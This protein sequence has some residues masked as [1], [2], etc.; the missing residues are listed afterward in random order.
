M[1]KSISEISNIH[2][3]EI[4]F[5][6]LLPTQFIVTDLFLIPI[7]IYTNKCQNVQNSK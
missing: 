3:Q 4:L 7:L 6:C 1:D 2:T 5:A